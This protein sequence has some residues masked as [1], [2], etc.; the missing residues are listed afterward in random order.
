[1]QCSRRLLVVSTDGDYIPLSM[2][3]MLR[4]QGAP[5]PPCEVFVFRMLTRSGADDAPTAK[6]QCLPGGAAAP[7]KPG[8]QYE[9]VHIAKLMTCITRLL[10]SEAQHP[11]EQ[12]CALVALG[13]CDFALNLPRLG[14]KSLWKLRHRLAKLDLS[15]PPQLLCA[16]SMLYWDTF[17][18]KNT[19]PSGMVN[20]VAFFAELPEAEATQ[21]YAAIMLRI[22]S[23]K[24]LSPR[25]A[26]A[27]WDA[28]RARAHALNTE[29][30]LAYWNLLQ[31]VP[32]PHSRDF[33]Y[34]RDAHGRTHFACIT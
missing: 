19:I 6:R 4:A 2:L 10:P 3:Q 31:G 24:T 15:R 14:P 25:I 7:R 18:M 16:M 9:F 27:L 22:K 12:F 13:G 28:D 8:R 26:S 1:M 23:I 34:R 29:W 32:D 17:V 21:H 20:S 30:T 5:D 33:G 11:V